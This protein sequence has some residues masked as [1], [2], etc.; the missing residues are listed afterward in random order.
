MRRASTLLDPAYPSEFLRS[1]MLRSDGRLASVMTAGHQ[2]PTR[3]VQLNCFFG[4]AVRNRRR[5]S[6][7]APRR[8]NKTVFSC[9]GASSQSDSRVQRSEDISM[10]SHHMK[11]APLRTVPGRSSMRTAPLATAMLAS[12][13]ISNSVNAAQ[14]S[15]SA[16]S[17]PGQAP[18]GHLQPRSDGFPRN[19]PAS[20]AEQEKLSNFDARQQ[21]LDQ[22]LDKAL[23][24]C[25]C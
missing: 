14:L 6:A 24:I 12:I 18:I 17:V 21:K 4:S 19:S 22:E 11:A 5:R 23:N 15:G 13:L 8:K 3:R 16:A 2:R 10:H 20:Q 7:I 1:K 9:A 25:R